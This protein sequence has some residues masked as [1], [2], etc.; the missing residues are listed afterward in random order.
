MLD[1]DNELKKNL[2]MRTDMVKRAV[3]CLF[4]NITVSIN[5][6]FRRSIQ[7]NECL[8]LKMDLD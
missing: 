7:T 3:F 8:L 1:L 6:L 2:E 4:Y 5:F